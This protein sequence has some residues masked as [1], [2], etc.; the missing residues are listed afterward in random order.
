M[1]GGLI[2]LSTLEINQN[3]FGPLTKNDKC[4]LI[5]GVLGMIN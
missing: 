5:F 4:V 1:Y 3:C 2:E